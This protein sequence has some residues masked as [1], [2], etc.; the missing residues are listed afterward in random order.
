MPLG[1]LTGVS[2]DEREWRVTEQLPCQLVTVS[3]R[4]SGRDKFHE[5]RQELARTFTTTTFA[6]V[7]RRYGF[8]DMS[9]FSRGFRAE[10]GLSP[11]EWRDRH[12]GRGNSSQE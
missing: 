9:R 4:Y 6:A 8:S 2:G 3:G 12:F 5:T 10:Y 1:N 11:S 7:A